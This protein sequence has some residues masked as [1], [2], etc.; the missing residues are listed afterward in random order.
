MI[1]GITGDF[2]TDQ[3]VKL[4]RETFGSWPKGPKADKPE[5]AY[6]KTVSP[7]IYYIEK[8]D[9]TQSNIIM[10]HLGITRRNPDYY[11]VEVL[12]QVMSGSFAS[13]LFTN[14]RSKKGL[15]Y[16]V[17]GSVG[18][19]YDH[20][21]TF[22]MWMTTQTEKT[23]AGIDALFE[24]AR[25]FTAVPITDE[26]VD[27]AKAGILN[28][29][30]FQSDSTFDILNQQITYEYYGYPL[31]W[32]QLYRDGIDKTTTAQVRKAAEKYVH[33]DQFAVLVVGPAEGRDRPLSE[34]GEV[35]A[36]D[37]TIPEPEV[38]KVAA[39]ADGLSRGK[40]LIGKAVE[41][42]G[43]AARVDGVER[44]DHSGSTVV[45]MP[46]GEMEL[47]VSVLKE[48]PDRVRQE[49]Q[50]P[51]GAMT[52][53]ISPEGAFMKSPQGVMPMPDSERE[54][55]LKEMLHDP[56]FLLSLRGESDFQA[57]ATGMVQVNGTDVENV[58][59]S[60]QGEVMTLGIDPKTGQCLQ[61]SYRGSAPMTGQPG[62]IVR[63]FSDFREVDGL[64]VPFVMSATFEG[65]PST[66]STIDSFRVNAPVD[67]TAFAMPQAGSGDQ[68]G[69]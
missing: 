36:I 15:A 29:F 64:V 16:A 34:F 49:L 35:V 27:K 48:F 6:N 5:V 69:K 39:T 8:S 42:M 10:G 20:L 47:K 43:G 25:N 58:E 63:T 13:R 23:A 12:N 32:L 33:P 56:I 4:V 7:G 68:G 50:T 55:V 31:D 24:E 28:S 19:T 65:K 51:M 61:M 2:D 45:T 54:K 1:L 9:M 3:A 60:V 38:E 46:Q 37:I 41:G 14:V 30:V 40:A 52:V 26:E 11:A 59:V 44:I 22:S 21:G 57:V 62:Q 53:V 17:T 66:S 67:E 18:S